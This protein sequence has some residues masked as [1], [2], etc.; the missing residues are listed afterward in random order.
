MRQLLRRCHREN[1]RE[2]ELD[3]ANGGHFAIA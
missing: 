1:I 2:R 3:R